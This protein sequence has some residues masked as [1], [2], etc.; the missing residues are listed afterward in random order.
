MKKI[1][2]PYAKV[3]GYNCFGCSHKNSLGL[4]LSFMETEEGLFCEWLPETQFQGWIGVLHGGIQATLLDE[5]ASWVVF[6]KCGISGVTSELKV[7]Y[8]KA[9]K[10]T[11]K[12][13]K[14][15]GEL[16]EMQRNIAIIDCY[17]YDSDGL[18]CAQAE[19]KY[20]TFNDEVSKRDY[21]YPGK[22]AFYE[23]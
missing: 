19:C 12:P 9:V 5:I 8:K 15:K 7:R 6:V 1:T 2:N 16:R 10:M 23:E 14:L 13:I 11:E 21:L 20:F 3:S 17:L 4:K 18:L 22:D